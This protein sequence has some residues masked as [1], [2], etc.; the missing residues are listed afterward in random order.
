[1]N[2]LHKPEKI[3]LPTSQLST[4][5][6]KNSVINGSQYIS[7]K[8]LFHNNGILNFCNKIINENNDIIEQF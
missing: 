2:Q 5:K 7:F 3:T 6:Y 8:D 4:S 1:M